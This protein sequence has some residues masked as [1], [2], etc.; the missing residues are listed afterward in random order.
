M[1]Y[2]FPFGVSFILIFDNVTEPHAWLYTFHL[3]VSLFCSI[4]SLFFSLLSIPPFFPLRLSFIYGRNIFNAILFI[5]HFIEMFV[6][7]SVFFCYCK[8]LILNAGCMY[9][10]WWQFA[11]C[12]FDG[13]NIM[14]NIYACLN[15]LFQFNVF[16]CDWLL[17][18]AH[19]QFLC[20]KHSGVFLQTI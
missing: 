16:L 19:F 11:Y 18:L 15:G 17:S 7:D 9:T 13:L 20:V 3:N 5:E 6:F 8:C 10:F 2:G 1:F 12:S 4:R 14:M